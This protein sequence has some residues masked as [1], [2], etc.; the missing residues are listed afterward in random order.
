MLRTARWTHRRPNPK[1]YAGYAQDWVGIRGSDELHQHEGRSNCIQLHERGLSEYS[2]ML[3]AATAQ[4]GHGNTQE[5]RATAEP[6]DCH[7]CRGSVSGPRL[8]DRLNEIL[9]EH[10]FDQK[11]EALCRKSYSAAE[12]A[13]TVECNSR[14]VGTHCIGRN[15]RS[16]APRRLVPRT[17]RRF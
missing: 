11:V 8:Y 9:D 3:A 12:K 5:A 16:L 13:A 14:R 10:H 4:A 17:S 2:G 15:R 6:L 1:Q 7:Q